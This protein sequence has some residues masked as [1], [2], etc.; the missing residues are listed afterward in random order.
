VWPWFGRLQHWQGPP[1]A[2]KFRDVWSLFQ[3]APARVHPQSVKTVGEVPNF[4]PN[5][6]LSPISAPT[7]SGFGTICAEICHEVGL[8]SVIDGSPLPGV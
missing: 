6:N 5:Y 4:A 7:P 3:P 8:V 1:A 2:L